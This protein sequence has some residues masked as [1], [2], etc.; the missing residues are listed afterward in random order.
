MWW[1][2]NY[3]AAVGQD[4]PWL[5]SLGKNMLKP[6]EGPHRFLITCTAN[7]RNPT[8]GCPEHLVDGALSI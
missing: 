5:L 3:V 2:S 7:R 4:G 8:P 1:H 6:M